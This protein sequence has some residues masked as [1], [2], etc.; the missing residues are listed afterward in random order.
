M[1]LLQVDPTSWW[2]FDETETIICGE[3]LN[4]DL[5][6]TRK[7]EFKGEEQVTM[8]MV[9]QLFDADEEAYQCDGC[10]TQSPGYDPLENPDL[11]D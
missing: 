2:E 6:K 9:H 11:D 8:N 4:E 3:C 7:G 1:G 5:E 10:N